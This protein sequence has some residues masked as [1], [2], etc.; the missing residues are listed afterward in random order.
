MRLD[1][2]IKIICIMCLS[3][4]IGALIVARNSPAIAYEP[5]IYTATPL[6]V[7]LVLFI[8]LVCGIGIVVQQVGSDRHTKDN[9]W[10][11]G[12]L[13]ILLS[14]TIILSLWI[15][16]GYALWCIGDPAVHL[17][18]IQNIISNE[19]I[20][21]GREN[22]YP[23]IH[24]YV[25][26]ISF[27]CGV[28][29]IMPHK[30]IP[31]IFALLYVVF[32]YLLIKSVLPDKGQVILALIASMTLMPPTYLNFTPNMEANFVFPLAVFLFIKSVSPGTIRWNILFIIMIF[33]FPVFHPVPSFALFVTMLMI[34]L[35][36]RWWNVIQWKYIKDRFTDFKF[37]ITASLLLLIWSISWFSEFGAWAHTIVNLEK[38]IMEGVG[39]WAT[40]YVEAALYAESVGFSVTQ[41]FFRIYGGNLIYVILALLS[42]PIVIK[43]FQPNL[44][45]L[46]YLYGPIAVIGS[47]TIMFFFL[48]VGFGPQRLVVYLTILCTPFVGFLLYEFLKRMYHF[49]ADTFL[50]ILAIGTILVFL[51]AVSVNGA[52]GLY[53]SPYIYMDNW[54]ITRTEIAGMDHFIH[55]KNT[56]IDTA[57]MRIMPGQYALFLL[58]Q[59]ELVGRQ[60]ILTHR[61]LI[62][63]ELR[64]PWHFGYDNHS[65]LGHWLA[66]DTYMVLT[67]RDKS[68]YGDIFPSMAEIRFMP[69]DFE[70]LKKDIA[71]DYIYSNGGLDV[72]FI[73]NTSIS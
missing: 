13:L 73:H 36:N 52:A 16:R 2:A 66:Q 69:H 27:I 54:Q 67:C 56:S 58:T 1:R 49:R 64:P 28:S 70:R 21:I 6:I 5:S 3:M 33:L 40:D 61:G 57:G 72:Y 14:Y 30:S 65:T 46:I 71:I 4:T 7:W 37:T 22:I 47:A 23:I 41:Y 35:G 10:L 45:K 19:H 24:I 31:L 50:K 42:L 32:M 34:W 68:A 38:S 17:G 8:N 12:I 63:E 26:Q 59:D 51:V 60:D 11:L 62:P 9:L 43:K 25:A 20:G 53:T 15:I 48:R 55:N 44:L 39:G 29:P 18:M